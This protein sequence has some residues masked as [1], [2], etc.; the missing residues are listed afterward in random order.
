MRPGAR[1]FIE[2][3]AGIEDAQVFGAD[4]LTEISV[5]WPSD[6]RS[7]SSTA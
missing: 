6:W 1:Q 5:S 3:Q 2:L 4:E 7:T